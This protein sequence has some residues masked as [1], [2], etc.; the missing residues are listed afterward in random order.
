M[1]ISVG[2]KLPEV[3]LVKA[4]AEGPQAVKSS[5][6]FAGKRVALFSVPGCLH[7]DLLG[8][9]PAGLRRKGRPTSRP[10]AWTKSSAPRSMMPS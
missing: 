10:R 5:E 1:T 7:P 8:Q 6:Y 3:T 4:T 2:D 9:A